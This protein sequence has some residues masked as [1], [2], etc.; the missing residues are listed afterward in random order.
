[1]LPPHPP[2]TPACGTSPSPS[3]F[4]SPLSRLVALVLLFLCSLFLLLFWRHVSRLPLPVC[5]LFVVCSGFVILRRGSLFV[6]VWRPQS[7]T[8]SAY[9]SPVRFWPL[10]ACFFSRFASFFPSSCLHGACPSSC[11]CLPLFALSLLWP[12]CVSCAFC[13]F[14]VPGRPLASAALFGRPL[15]LLSVHPLS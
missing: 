5:V 1:L 11:G 10:P 12:H 3:K 13:L 14:C 15:R 7:T 4:F 9:L 6:S 2:S 8:P